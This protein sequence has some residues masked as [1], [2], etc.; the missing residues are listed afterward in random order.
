MAT[1]V[2][3]ILWEHTHGQPGWILQERMIRLG[4]SPNAYALSVVPR[5]MRTSVSN[6][7][8]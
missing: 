3:D 5:V 2:L 6:V 7:M 1:P 8:F 4:M